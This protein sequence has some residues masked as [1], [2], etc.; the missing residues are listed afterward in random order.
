MASPANAAPA[1]YIELRHNGQP[2]DPT[3]WF[4]NQLSQ[5]PSSKGEG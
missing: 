2:I 1:L 5:G 4:G 3:P